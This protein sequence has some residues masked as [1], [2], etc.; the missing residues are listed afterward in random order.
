MAKK[1]VMASAI[2][3]GREAAM[4][5]VG[6]G[7]SAKRGGAMKGR[8]AGSGIRKLGKASRGVRKTVNR[9]KGSKPRKR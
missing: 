9:N 8:N 4:K 5:A 2:A 7:R 1:G 3:S 6:K